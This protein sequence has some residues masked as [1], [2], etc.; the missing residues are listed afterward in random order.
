MMEI[1]SITAWAKQRG[2]VFPATEIYG[3]FAN[4]Y[5]YGPYGS[6]L[7]KNIRDLWWRTFVEQRDDIVGIDGD[8]ITTARI[9]E[10]SGHTQNFDDLLLVDPETQ[11]RFRADHLIE[12]QEGINVEGW[13]LERINE[14]LQSHQIL[15]PATKKPLRGPVQR[16]NMMF[17]VPLAKTKES[18]Q[19]AFLRP[20]TAQTMFTEW[21]NVVNTQR[22]ELPFGVAQ[23][24]RAFRNE[25]TPGN[26]IF[27]R[28]EFEQMEIEY[29]I[30]PPPEWETAAEKLK[31]QPHL[32]H[33]PQPSQD[34]INQFMDRWAE[35]MKDWCQM[36]GL[37]PSS[38]ELVEHEPAQLSHYSKRTFDFEYHFPFGRKE[39]YGCAYRTDFDLRS[40][41]E[42]SQR[43][44]RYRDPKTNETFIPHVIEPTFGLD[45]TFLAVICSAL[46]T[47]ELSDGSSRTVLKIPSRLAPVK[48]TV[49][50]LMKK[51]GLAEKARLIKSGLSALGCVEY[52]EK[53]SVGKR[54][55]RQDEIGTPVCLTVDYQTLEDDT[56]TVR[57]RDQMTQE[58]VPVAEVVP[59]WYQH[60]GA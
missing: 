8:T 12:D 9:W 20:E 33:W 16:F 19:T 18:D 32:S 37:K 29:F 22:P 3:G 30:P 51:D 57:D 49:L 7:K 2:F 39:L 5:I 35:T 11:Q 47:E 1:N 50:P 36:I 56:V 10:A 23:I 13:E 28:L 26:F 40:H 15:S 52:D 25:I 34:Y 55:R 44:L 27:R 42:A 21:H 60:Y 38:Y 4:S 53:G 14:F 59:W 43:D 54:Y 17:Q 31:T 58:R 24:G 46:Q 48:A 6:L 45:R 41:Q